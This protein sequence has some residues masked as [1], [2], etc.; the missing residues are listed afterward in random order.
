VNRAAH[1]VVTK[2]PKPKAR[3]LS[4]ASEAAFAAAVQHHRAGHLHEAEQFYRQVLGAN[5][6]H[7]D[8][9]H[10]LGVLAHQVGHHDVA[11]DL[12]ERAIE[13]DAT[14]ALYQSNLG[15]ALRALG[16]PDRATACY[17][18]AIV[19]RPRY[20]EAYN[21]LAATL[22]EHDQPDEAV[23]WLR[24]AIALKPDFPEVHNNLG[25][26][27]VDLGQ[28]DKAIACYRRAVALRPDYAEAHN[29]LG[30]G[31][32]ELGALEAA[33]VS[34]RTSLALQPTIAETHNNL[35]IVL[36]RLGRLDEAVACCREAITL[37]PDLREAYDT[38]A[39]TLADQGKLDEA[40]AC[41]RQA[42]ALRPDEPRTHDN[43]GTVLKEQGLPKE[44]IACFRTAI[45]LK[46]DLPNAHRNLAMALLAQGDMAEG[47][48]EYEWRWQTADMAGSR[49]D[50]TQPQ[51]FGE[52]AEGRTLLIHA[53]QGL[54]DTVQFC[55]YTTLAATRGLHV[56]MEVQAPLVRLLSGLPGVDQV[57]ASG[58]D[59]PPFDL[60]CPMQ[61]MPLALGTTVPTIPSAV[62]YL[63]ADPAQAAAWQARLGAIGDL[64]PRIGLA[65]AGNPRMIRDSQR[66]LNPDRLA[67]LF[68][69]AGLHFISLQQGGPPAPPDAGLTD[70]MAEMEDFADTASLIANL[71][72]VISVDTAVA[73]L[74]AALGK[75]VWLLDRFDPDWRWLLGRRDSPWYPSL[76]VYRQPR[77]R[78][79]D[80]VL[81]EAAQ[82]LHRL[83]EG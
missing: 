53:E 9:L 82:D 4:P 41:Y 16:R 73:H 44:A 42:L 76:R 1:L 48:R 2:L 56:I 31:L 10:L 46:P 15:N 71:D 47:W 52:P 63:H 77:P 11:V 39:A 67:P 81:A 59:L 27:F 14:I 51:W 3:K 49:R 74:A 75:P 58:H 45:A 70:V 7:A 19:L 24:K 40:A 29:N 23:T 65:W 26:L 18:R 61:S 69:L 80:S 37:K 83:A 72:L 62:S 68:G 33:V 64:G 13:I 28:P 60:H 36:Q 21:N 79:W 22:R 57:V 17:R 43:L 30:A 66:S 54:G 12:I 32:K 38:L 25:N 6:S 8:S 50:F 55:R 78:D 35:G 20:V 5:P 34:Y